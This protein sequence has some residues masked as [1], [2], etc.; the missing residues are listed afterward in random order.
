MSKENNNPII[1]IITRFSEKENI[2]RCLKSVY[3]QTYPNIHH[4]ITY[5]H[6]EDK[7]YLESKLSPNT[8][9]TLVKVPHLKAIKNLSYTYNYHCHHTKFS[10]PNYELWD[11]KPYREDDMEIRKE[12][13]VIRYNG[14]GTWCETLGFT[15]RIKVDHFPYNLYLK[16]A[17][18]FVKEGWIFYLDNDDEIVDPTSISQLAENIKEKSKDT[19]HIVKIFHSKQNKIKPNDFWWRY[20]IGHP[21]VLNDIGGCNIVF[22]TKYCKYTVWDEWRGADYRTAKVLEEIIPHKNFID[23]T[24]VNVI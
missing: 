19:L 18:K 5:E 12:V 22:H 23:K 6:N 3:E 9:T 13:E 8:D 24:F 16:E 21:L 1:N 20:Q 15:F 11:K 14:G 7:E 10:E 17:E 4:I 2:D